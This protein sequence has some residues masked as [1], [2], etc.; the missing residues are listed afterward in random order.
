MSGSMRQ[1]TPRERDPDYCAYVAACPCVACLVLD[2][3]VHYGVHFA[4]IRMGSRDHD[5]R[6]TG[7][8]EKPDDKW[9]APLCPPHHVGD[10]RVTKLTQHAQSEQAFWDSLGIDVF[11]MCKSLWRTYAGGTPGFG[12]I[13]Q[14]AAMGRRKIDQERN[15]GHG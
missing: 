5:K 13:A 4:H 2:G 10:A 11:E 9:G 8:Q 15:L 7:M 14:Y 6:P 1:R 12:V 3:K